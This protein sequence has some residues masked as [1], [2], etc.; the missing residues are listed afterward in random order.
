MKKYRIIFTF[1]LCMAVLFSN[2]FVALAETP[3]IAEA[4]TTYEDLCN[5]FAVTTTV[6]SFPTTLRASTLQCKTSNYSH[7]G[8]WIATVTLYANFSYN[9]STVSVS[10]S[11]ANRSLASG[12]TYSGESISKN[13]GTASLSA[14]LKKGSTSSLPISFSLTCDKN[15]NVS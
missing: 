13:G 14:T 15:G 9:G 3:E 7:N 11:Y 5:G 6:S 2:C 4:I 8:N 1:V 10:S 12:W